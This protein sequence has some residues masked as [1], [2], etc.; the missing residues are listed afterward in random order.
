MVDTHLHI[1]KEY[2]DDIDAVIDRSISNGVNYMIV[3]GTSSKDNAEVLE[4]V[5]KYDC[6]YGALGL[7]PQ[8]IDSDYE[9]VLEFISS[10]VRD[11]K[12]V[13]IGEIGLDRHYDCDNY[14][15][16]KEVFERQLRLAQEY[17]IPVIIHSRD[18]IEDT[19]NILSKYKVRGV[20]HCFNGSVEMAKKFVDLGFYIGVG[21]IITFKNSKKIKEVIKIVPVE[22]ILLETDSPYLTP[23]PL[24]G[25]VNEPSNIPII[26]DEICKIKGLDI[27]SAKVLILHNVSRLFDKMS[28]L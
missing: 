13:A 14:E 8:E 18:C 23:E 2:Y 19:Y 1:F 22:Y 9:V 6:V 11:N 4:L 15:L 10:H 7:Q 25:T 12:I 28:I 24:R 20:L 21:G 16:Q 5:Q 17:D 3:N 26:L 27:D